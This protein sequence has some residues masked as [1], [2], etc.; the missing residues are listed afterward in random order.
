MLSVRYFRAFLRMARNGKQ[1]EDVGEWGSENKKN[2]WMLQKAICKGLK[3]IS[4][5]IPTLRT[6]L[7]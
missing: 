1:V 6:K 2:N 5:P 3:V 7:V 4:R